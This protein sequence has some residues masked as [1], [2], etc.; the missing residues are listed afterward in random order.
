[1]DRPLELSAEDSGTE[2]CPITYRA[3]PQAE[4]RV[5][6]GKVLGRWQVVTDPAVLSRLD[7][8]ARGQVFRTDLRAQGISDDRTT[9]P[10]N[11]PWHGP[12]PGPSLV[13]A[14]VLEHLGLALSKVQAQLRPP[15]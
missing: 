1:M 10:V 15:A 14:S 11:G 6:G 7:A 8:A 13:R 9:I 3:R 2:A 4:V 12:P 5:V